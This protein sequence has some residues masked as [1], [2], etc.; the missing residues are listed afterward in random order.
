MLVILAGFLF[1]PH[2][3]TEKGKFFLIVLLLTML[4]VISDMVAWYADEHAINS[5]LQFTANLLALTDMCMIVSV[6]GYYIFALIN[7]K[8]KAGRT[9]AHIILIVNS[10]AVIFTV[11]AALCGQ[12]FRQDGLYYGEGPL[13]SVCNIVAALSLLSLMIVSLINRKWIGSHATIALVIYCTLPLIGVMIELFVENYF[14]SYIAIVG[15]LQFIYTMLQSSRM[16][17]LETRERVLQKMSYEDQLTGL[18]NRRACERDIEM[19]QAT[20]NIGIVFCN[21]NGLKHTNVEFG[22]ESGDRVLTGFAELM[23]KNLPTEFLYRMNGDEFVAMIPDTEEDEF[24]RTE[25]TIRREIREHTDIAAAGFA[26]GSGIEVNNL[27]R[28]AEQ[29]MYE[30]KKLFYKTHR[31]YDRNE[32]N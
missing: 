20:D 6:F 2:P 22:Y 19:I 27:L 11:I 15:S 8:K 32:S 13:F 7:E 1:I 16:D 30:D 10:A 9:F 5:E 24:D 25:Q 23:K 31:K 28:T 14:L 12:V 4:G 29:R 3:R 21:L 18:K 17:D 26:W